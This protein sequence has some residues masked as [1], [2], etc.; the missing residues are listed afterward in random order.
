MASEPLSAEMLYEIEDAYCRANDRRYREREGARVWLT[1]T[2]VGLLLTEVQR[3][4]AALAATRRSCAFCGHGEA[5]HEHGGC[6]T[7]AEN[8]FC[9]CAGFT[10]EG[11]ITSPED[12]LGMLDYEVFADNARLT[13]ALAAAEEALESMHGNEHDPCVTDAFMAAS[14]IVQLRERLEA[15]RDY[16]RALALSLDD[17]VDTLTAALTAS[18][19]NNILDSSISRVGTIRARVEEC[20]RLVELGGLPTAAAGGAAGRGGSNPPERSGH[21]EA[22]CSS[23]ARSRGVVDGS[24]VFFC[25]RSRR[26]R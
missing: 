3:L 16:A 20:G 6:R 18:E 11:T 22:F 4:T 25:P 17:D 1:V 8:S 13:A 26:R 19:G 21:D 24:P 7:R 12:L 10:Q 14:E 23:R 2:A 15:E 5:I 9:G